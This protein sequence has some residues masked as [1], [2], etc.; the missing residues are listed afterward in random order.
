MKKLLISGA[1]LLAA[2]TAAA[3]SPTTVI[4]NAT[5]IDG[6]GRAPQPNMTIV[7]TGG[8]IADVFSSGSK[9]L[10]GNAQIV[11][12]RGRF[13][14]PGLI[15]AHVHNGTIQERTQEITE[16]ILRNAL[17]G[18]VTSVRDMGG[19]SSNVKALA[20]RAALDTMPW[21][22]LYLSAIIAGPGSWF[23]GARG[24]YMAEGGLAGEAP[25][26]R[27]VVRPADIALA[28]ASAK[29]N[30]A[31]GIKLYN[32]LDPA[33]LPAIVAEAKKHGLRVWSH[34]AVDPGKPSDLVRAG[35]HVL[36]HADQFLAEVFP[37]PSTDLSRDSARALR[38]RAFAS[39][40]FDAPALNELI[41]LMK[42]NGTMVDATLFIMT[43]RPDSSGHIN[44]QAATLYRFATGMIRRANTAGVPIVAGTDALG[45][46]SPNIH[47]E[48]QL[49]VE[50]AGL[51]PM[52]ALQA[53]TSNAAR[54]I[55]AQDSIGT[56]ER[57][58]IADL[59]ILERDPLVDIANTLTVKSV[60]K[61]GRLY[62]RDS[63]VRV[64][65]NARA[66][67]R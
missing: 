61:A 26:V 12:A 53:A 27:R 20:S 13:V 7:V 56:I 8:R 33:L 32:N 6:T 36:S 37:W 39:T 48:L 11:E 55:G 34:L 21:P 54:A 40:P 44:E 35:V 29:T 3:Q 57:G 47:A 38:Q 5:V 10:P 25:L 18:G 46:S 17:M 23:E 9:Q 30:G 43:P 62:H 4:T 52:Q 63:P 22:R 2:G 64:P 58:K 1:L 49:L 14:I 16:A 19:R 59:V 66:P 51:S 45:G 24:A 50:R 42:Q 41:V 65:P 60:M 28:I 15:D 31:T 67:S